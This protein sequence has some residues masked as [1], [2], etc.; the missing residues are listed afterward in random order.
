LD[1]LG[2]DTS[3]KLRLQLLLGMCIITG[4]IFLCLSILN[5]GLTSAYLL[6]SLQLVFAIFSA[7][8]VYNLRKKKIQPW[9]QFC[10]LVS[11]SLLVLFAAHST[12]LIKA[13]YQWSLIF[14]MMYYFLLGRKYA[15]LLCIGILIGQVSIIYLKIGILLSPPIV[16]FTLCF[17]LLWNMSHIYESARSRSEAALA[18]LALK[19]PLTQANNRLALKKTFN[20]KL[21]SFETDVAQSLYFMVIDVDHFKQVNDIYGHETGDGVL[22]EVAQRLFS[23]IGK[24]SIFRIGGEEFCVMHLCPSLAS[25]SELAE[26]ARQ[27]INDKTFNIK[28]QEIFLTISIGV[29]GFQ[30]GMQ[31]NQVLNVA[32]E[33]LYLAK[34]QGRNCVVT[35]PRTEAL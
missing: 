17:L 10:Y 34:S 23:L 20:E 15:W 28:D 6:G 5:L 27:V 24:D 26:S 1:S 2:L 33:A 13:A 9:M 8:F 14:P 29:C 25:A 31:L 12:A 30:A 32:D 18:E 21:A 19:D 16:N 35:S 4:G 22:V 11:L 3:S 7:Y